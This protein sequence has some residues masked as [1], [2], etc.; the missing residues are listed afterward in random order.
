MLPDVSPRRAVYIPVQ[1]GSVDIPP[2]PVRD[3]TTT[4]TITERG[5]DLGLGGLPFS[6]VCVS[7]TE[8]CM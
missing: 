5:V 4:F 7:S 3:R 1:L 2:L 8:I 6:L